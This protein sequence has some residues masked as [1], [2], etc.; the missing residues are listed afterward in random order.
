MGFPIRFSLNIFC[1]DLRD[2]RSRFCTQNYST[3]KKCI[4]FPYS[5]T[6]AGEEPP[7][8]WHT[9][10]GSHSLNGNREHLLLSFTDHVHGKPCYNDW[11]TITQVEQVI[12]FQITIISSRSHSHTKTPCNLP[13]HMYAQPG[14]MCLSSQ[15]GEGSRPLPDISM[16]HAL[17]FYALTLG[18]LHTALWSP[19]HCIRRDTAKKGARRYPDG[20]RD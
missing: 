13:I 17:S 8:W 10:S 19:F 18:W 20:F 1:K 14:Q 15:W 4:I 12:T 9:V 2:E 5:V 6:D 16:Q 3:K 11:I 7:T